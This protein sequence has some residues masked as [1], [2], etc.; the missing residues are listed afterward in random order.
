MVFNEDRNLT[1]SCAYV[2]TMEGQYRV[3]IKFAGKEIPK[4][5]FQVN[6]EGAAGDPE[7]VHASGPGIE[8]VGNQ[9]AKRTFFNIFTAGGRKGG[10]EG[11]GLLIFTS[12]EPD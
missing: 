6:V 5:P 7:K 8:P 11:C 10:V 2:P 3:I 4:S 9:V 1:Y 12:T